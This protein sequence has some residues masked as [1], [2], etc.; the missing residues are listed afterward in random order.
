MCVKPLCLQHQLQ[1]WDICNYENKAIN[2]ALYEHRLNKSLT[3]SFVGCKAFK[4]IRSNGI[5]LVRGMGR[6]NSKNV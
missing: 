2:R 5:F 1:L 4:E 6:G 3:T